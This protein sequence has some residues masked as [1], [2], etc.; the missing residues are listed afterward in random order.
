MPSANYGEVNLSF[1]LGDTWN[2]ESPGKG[3]CDLF[4]GGYR[5]AVLLCISFFTGGKGFIS[6]LPEGLGFEEHAHL[7][8]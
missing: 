6:E 2:E 3:I 1:E 5:E 4:G 7:Y 8:M